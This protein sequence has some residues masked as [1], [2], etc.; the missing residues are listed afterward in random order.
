MFEIKKE[1]NMF[2]IFMYLFSLAISAFGNI[3]YIEG[4]VT[5]TSLSLLFFMCDAMK[6]LKEIRDRK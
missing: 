3:P 5:A 1:A 4:V 6:A 2:Y